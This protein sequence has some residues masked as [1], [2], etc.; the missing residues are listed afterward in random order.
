M[1]NAGCIAIFQDQISGN[2]NGKPGKEES[3]TRNLTT[4]KLG[5]YLGSSNLGSI[6]K[7]QVKTDLSGTVRKY[8][9]GITTVTLGGWH[10]RVNVSQSI[11]DTAAT[12][13]A[14]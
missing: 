8:K 3:S 14:A 13:K 11:S 9:F 2:S 6:S 5:T 10:S 4:I 1:D 12:R 7:T